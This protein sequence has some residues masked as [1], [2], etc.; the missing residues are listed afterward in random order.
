GNAARRANE[1]T[2]NNKASAPPPPCSPS[3]A[4]SS[5]TTTGNLGALA[6]VGDVHRL[7]LASG[8]RL[9]AWEGL[10]VPSQAGVTWTPDGAS[11]VLDVARDRRTPDTE[12]LVGTDATVAD[13]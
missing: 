3:C 9:E 11:L 7:S 8:D 6:P 2:V 12:S 5:G 10:Q 13:C 4:L 1:V